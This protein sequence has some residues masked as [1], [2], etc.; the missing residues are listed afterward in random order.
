LGYIFL[1]LLPPVY[2]VCFLIIW[3]LKRMDCLADT[4]EPT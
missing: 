3:E 4:V 1:R 2:P